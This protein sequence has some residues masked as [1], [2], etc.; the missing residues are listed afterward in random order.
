M[1]VQVQFQVQGIKTIFSPVT[2]KFKPKGADTSNQHG[3]RIHISGKNPMSAWLWCTK[4]KMGLWKGMFMTVNWFIKASNQFDLSWYIYNIK[5]ELLCTNLES[6]CQG[7]TF[8]NHST[9]VSADKPSIF[10]A[11]SQYIPVYLMKSWYRSYFPIYRSQFSLF[12]HTNLIR[13][14]CKSAFFQTNSACFTV[15][16]GY[17]CALRKPQAATQWR[18]RR[19]RAAAAK[20]WAYDRWVILISIYNSITIYNH[21]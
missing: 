3:I 16:P 8:L 1:P 13:K 11:Y 21:L 4:N 20:S 12:S 10:D 5:P 19:P 15:T 6:E 14:P 17:G 9:S 7:S 18:A 2:H